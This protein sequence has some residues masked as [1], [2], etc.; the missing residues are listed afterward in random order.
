MPSEF[1][2][3]PFDEQSRLIAEGNA[4]L[5]ALFGRRIKGFVPPWNTYDHST[6]RALA[7]AGFE[8]LSAGPEFIESDPLPVVPATCSLHNA[9]QAVEGAW[10]FQALAPLVVVVFH[11]DDFHEFKLQPLPDDPPS[12]TSLPELEALLD[13]I[14]DSAWIRTEALG[15]IAESVR[16]GTPLCNPNGLKLPDRVKALVPLILTRSGEWVTGPGIVWGAIRRHW[17][18]GRGPAPP[19]H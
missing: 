6:L 9:R 12:F 18:N 16:N 5:A 8:F 2:G 10:Y 4:H 19:D 13:W 1:F 3:V 15:S 7:L 17:L 14:K 11:P